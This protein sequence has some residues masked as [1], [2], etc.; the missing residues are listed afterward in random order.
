M[1]LCRY[2]DN[3]VGVVDGDVIIDVTPVTEALPAVRW[4]LP[5]G[6]LLIANLDRL[7]P[8]IKELARTGAR[9]PI[10][11]VNLLSPVA[12]P[13]KI[14]GFG[15][16]YKAHVEEAMKDPLMSRHVP[17]NPGTSK[18]MMVKANTS[19][20]GPSEGVALRFLDQR[21]DPELEFAIIFGRQ[22]TNIPKERA[23]EM[24]AGYAIGFDMSLRG[25]APPSSRKSID[26]YSVLGP[27]IVTPD[28]IP[29]PDDIAFTLKVNGEVRQQASTR[30]LIFSI[31]EQIEHAASFYTLYP[32]DILMTGTPEGVAQVRPGDVMEAEMAGIGKMTVKV[33]AHMV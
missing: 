13:G 4:P 30:D 12:N 16:A 15:Q 10:S 25:P 3:R 31:A 11:T 26:T 29:N 20:V 21:T 6:D 22:G 5:M 7:M 33:R 23:F 32:G 9:K 27:W 14:M 18:R 1:R 28:E 17:A 8:R 19:L 24:V 2:D